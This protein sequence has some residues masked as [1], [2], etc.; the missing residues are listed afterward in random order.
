MGRTPNT[1]VRASCMQPVDR[2]GSIDQKTGFPSTQPRDRGR[3]GTPRAASR[4]LVEHAAALVVP[5]LP[6]SL[7]YVLGKPVFWWLHAG[8]AHCCIGGPP[9]SSIFWLCAGVVH[10]LVAVSPSMSW[11]H[12][13]SMR[14]WVGGVP[15]PLPVVL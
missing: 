13:V 2:G 14:F 15:P 6:P 10:S 9:H 5:L 3:G 4:A 1:A 8:G 11:P 12:V 7:G